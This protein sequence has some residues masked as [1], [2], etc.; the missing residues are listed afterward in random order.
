LDDLLAGS[1][2]LDRAQQRAQLDALL[3]AD[4]VRPGQGFGDEAAVRRWLGWE[5]AH[6]ILERPLARPA[7][8]MFSTP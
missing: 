1:D 6:G 3:S 7:G 2:G 5:T 8:G 4:A